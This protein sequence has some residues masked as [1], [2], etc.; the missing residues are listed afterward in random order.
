MSEAVLEMGGL[1][2][3]GT[4]KLVEDTE[5]LIISE[6][7]SRKK[8]NKKN[9]VRAAENGAQETKEIESLK[10]VNRDEKEAERCDVI[11]DGDE[12]ASGSKKK[13]KNKKEQQNGAADEPEVLAA[14]DAAAAENNGPIPAAAKKKNKSAAAKKANKA[15]KQQTDPPSVPVSELFISGEYPVGQIM[16][17]PLAANDQKAKV[18]QLAVVT[19]I[20]V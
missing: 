19:L 3:G 8:K 11:C 1:E 18:S 14:E 15:L 6:D 9:K 17:H 16:E 12:K 7:G 20:Q 2:T 4:T 13:K 10:L 5:R